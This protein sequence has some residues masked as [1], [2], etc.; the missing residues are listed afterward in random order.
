MQKRLQQGRNDRT[1]QAAAQTLRGCG[2]S[3]RSHC[4]VFMVGDGVKPIV[5]AA[6][7]VGPQE[8]RRKAEA[9]HPCQRR[10]HQRDEERRIHHMRSG[11]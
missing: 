3:T 4:V 2:G 8:K 9:L 7:D 10:R 6:S 5:G 1:R 11:N